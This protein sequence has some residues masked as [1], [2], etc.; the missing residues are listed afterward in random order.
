MKN[1]EMLKM[2][3]KLAGIPSN[4]YGTPVGYTLYQTDNK[5]IIW[6]LS[7]TNLKKSLSIFCRKNNLKLVPNRY[8]LRDQRPI[9]YIVPDS[10]VNLYE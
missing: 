3:F 2:I 10:R 4:P 5:V 6:D 1:L 7:D 9:Y 8:S